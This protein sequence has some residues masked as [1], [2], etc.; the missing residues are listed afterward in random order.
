MES[1]YYKC[2]C[3]KC[4]RKIL[5]EIGLIGTPH[6]TEPVVTCAACLVIASQYKEK[7]PA[8]AQ[9]IEDW[10]KQTARGNQ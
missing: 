6:N 10:Q 4:G 3:K 9:D 7:F 1:A 5:V 2:Q 8:Q